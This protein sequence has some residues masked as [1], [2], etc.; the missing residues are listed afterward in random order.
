[1]KQQGR[2]DKRKRSGKILFGPTAP[3]R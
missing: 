2:E 1:M 3:R